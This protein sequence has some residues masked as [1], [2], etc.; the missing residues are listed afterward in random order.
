MAAS[1]SEKIRKVRKD[2]GLTLEGLANKVGSSKSYIWQIE[3]DSK[4]K[5]S[6][7]LIAKIAEALDVTVD[8]LVREEIKETYVPQPTSE[9][10]VFL[11]RKEAADFLKISLPTLDKWTRLGEIKSYKVVNQIRYKKQ[12]LGEAY[13]AREFVKLSP[14]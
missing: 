12:E 7:Q 6:A 13:E 10:E 9:Q 1:L 14:K 5:P 11:T 2:K 3:T 4:I 8:Y